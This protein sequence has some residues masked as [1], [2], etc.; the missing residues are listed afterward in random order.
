MDNSLKYLRELKKNIEETYITEDEVDQ[1]FIE[2]ESSLSILRRAIDESEHHSENKQM[3]ID[4]FVTN[5]AHYTMNAIGLPTS[6]DTFENKID[7]LFIEKGFINAVGSDGDT[8][9]SYAAETGNVGRVRFL[10]MSRADPNI[11]D[12]EAAGLRS[13]FGNILFNLWIVRQG[14]E[15]A[16]L[17]RVAELFLEK[18]VVMT[19]V[20]EEFAYLVQSCNN[21]DIVKKLIDNG[22]DLNQEAYLQGPNSSGYD[23][24]PL[25]SACY[26]GCMEMMRL[27]YEN[28]ARMTEEGKDKIFLTIFYAAGSELAWRHVLDPLI[29]TECKELLREVIRYGGRIDTD[30]VIQEIV[31][32]TELDTLGELLELVLDLAEEEGINRDEFI[33]HHDDEGQSPLVTQ[34][35]E[36]L[37][38]DREDG[39]YHTV[40][41]KVQALLDNGADPAALDMSLLEAIGNLDDQDA[42]ELI[43]S[44]MKYHA[45]PLMK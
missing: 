15:H 16:E 20:A 11:F 39:E 34:A 18:G 36:F 7:Y 21:L 3:L 42:F 37:R 45:E 29:P 33:N 1:A 28:G 32:W 35:R 27:L 17:T 2:S 43:K 5:D 38:V 31:E 40:F 6:P 14:V 24:T 44:Y 26:G 41:M 13:P 30:G 25:Y 9:L 10:L 8:A 22:I 19:G 4:G 12:H 23:T